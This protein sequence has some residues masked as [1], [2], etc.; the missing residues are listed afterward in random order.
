[1]VKVLD[2]LKRVWEHKNKKVKGFT[3]KYGVD[4]LVYYE[5]TNDV[6]IAIQR[7]K[8]LKKWNRRWKLELIEKSNPNWN[9]LSK[10]WIPDLVGDDRDREER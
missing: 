5:Q 10:D 4:R 2:L 1:V 9:D 8:Q 7:E 3:E 6:N